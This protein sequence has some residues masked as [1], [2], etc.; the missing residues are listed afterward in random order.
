M[1]TPRYCLWHRWQLQI[2]RNFE[3]DMKKHTITVGENYENEN[4]SGKCGSYECCHVSEQS[5]GNVCAGK[6][7]RVCRRTDFCERNTG[8]NRNTFRKFTGTEQQCY[9]RAAGTGNCRSGGG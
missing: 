7:C 1:Q 2:I 9:R 5:S 8:S 3:W 6:C 4:E